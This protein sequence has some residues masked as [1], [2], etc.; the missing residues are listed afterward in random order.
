MEDS[1][2]KAEALNQFQS[3]FT[4]ENMTSFL[5]VGTSN[6]RDVRLDITG[7][8]KLLQHLSINKAHGPD[9]ISCRILKEAAE[10]ISRFK[11]GSSGYAVVKLL[12][13]GARGPGSRRFDF[14]DWLPVSPASKSR[15]G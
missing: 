5:D 7:I 15:Y 12:A 9:N 6:I 14:R 11:F 2:T 4:Q 8:T 13:C 3:G 1:T 10:E